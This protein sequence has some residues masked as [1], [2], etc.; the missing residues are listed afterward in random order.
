[1]Q[2]G[3]I[4]RSLR[5]PDDQVFPL[6]K[7][8]GLDGVEVVVRE[9]FPK[10]R[11][12]DSAAR[13]RLA[14]SAG[15]HG[16]TIASVLLSTHGRLDFP[17]DDVRRA[18]GRQMAR[19]TLEG[20]AEMGVPVMMIP[21]FKQ[22]HF[23][24]VL[25]LERAVEDLCRLAPLAEQLNVVIG[26]ETLLP[27]AINQYLIEE[28]SSSHVKLYYDAGNTSNYGWDPFAELPHLAPFICRHHIKDA[29]GTLGY[30]PAAAGQKPPEPR[31]RLGDGTLDLPRWLEAIRAT[32]YDD[33]LMLETSPAGE[34]PVAE[35][36]YNA[37]RLR[38]L[39][40]AAGPASAAGAHGVV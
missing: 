27:G 39:V 21:C 13:Q 16:L 35:A 31:L 5:V 33:W 26:L 11:F 15:D 23:T 28:V 37:R 10:D 32:G 17:A 14:R 7:E 3:Y 20:C 40:Q 4:D 6:I 1:M 38:E 12:W 25:Q 34:D 24:T 19:A 29:R 8:I 22:D 36:R 18:L 30:R 9:E 2:L